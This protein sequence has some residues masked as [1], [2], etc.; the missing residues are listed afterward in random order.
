MTTGWRRWIA[1]AALAVALVS[2]AGNAYLL[3]QLRHPERWAVPAASRLVEAWVGPG[4]TFRDTVRI[5]AGTP[6][7][8]DVPVDER[9]S[10]RVDT[11]LPLNTTVRVPLRG[12]FGTYDVSLPIRADVPLRT[13]LPLQVRHTFRLRT[14]TPEPIEIPVEIHL[15]DLVEG[16]RR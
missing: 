11:V 15:G 1:P 3:W 8:L 14:R 2:L 12:P 7:R 16:M 10:I 4:A 9:F 13:T 5:P 6:L